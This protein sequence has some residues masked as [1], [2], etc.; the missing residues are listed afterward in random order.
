M[1]MRPCL[2]VD[3][4]ACGRLTASGSRCVDCQRT[5]DRTTLRGKRLR[6]PR[7]SKAEEHRRVR[8]VAT[9]RRDY[10]DVCP[11]WHRPP[12]PATD[13]TAD[14]LLPVG[15]GGMEA[16]PLGVLCRVCNGAKQ[17]HTS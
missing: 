9:W 11:G 1:T 2:G 17:D 4:H 5:Y 15:A 13:L 6:R 3:G 16:G 12:H 8:V 10:G 14:H 7:V